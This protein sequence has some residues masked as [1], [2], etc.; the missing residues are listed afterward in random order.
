[1]GLFSL[2]IGMDMSL[3]F[4]FDLRALNIFAQVAKTGNMSKTADLLGITQSSISQTLSNLEESLQTRLLD[5]SIRPMELTTAGRFLYDRS[6]VLLKEAR[7]TGLAIKHADYSQL[8]HINVSVIDSLVTSVGSALVNT[9]AKR[10]QDWSISTGLSHLHGHALLSRN[11]DIII[12]DDTLED[13]AD[14]CR[15]K[16]LREPFILVLPTGYDKPVEDLTHLLTNLDFIRYSDNS[17][18]GRSI[19]RHLR[20]AHVEPIKRLQLDNSYAVI[21]SVAAN[22]GWTMTT[23]LCLFQSGVEL[24][25]IKILPLPIEPLYRSITLIAR[26]HELGDLPRKMAKDITTTL[27]QDFI[28]KMSEKEP[29]LKNLLHLD[30]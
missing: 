9:V 19:E 13:Y 28:L 18:I 11:S 5:R 25:Q 27:K 7:K 22:L 23:P 15:F 2:F 6:K 10:A 8:R 17:L 21:S 1:M 20:S 12:S 24:H 3:L 16:I 29:W 26:K 4:E 30:D 14:L